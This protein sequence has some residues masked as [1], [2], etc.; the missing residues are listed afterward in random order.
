MTEIAQK[1][2]PLTQENSRI[3]KPTSQTLLDAQLGFLDNNSNSTATLNFRP[4][5][6]EAGIESTK[7]NYESEV[8]HSQDHE[9]D[10]KEKIIRDDSIP[11]E[12]VI[13]IK[14]ALNF[15]ETAQVDSRAWNINMACVLCWKAANQILRQEAAYLFNM[16]HPSKQDNDGIRSRFLRFAVVLMF[17]IIPLLIV[18]AEVVILIAILDEGCKIG[19]LISGDGTFQLPAF[20][21]VKYPQSKKCQASALLRD[22][23]QEPNDPSTCLFYATHLANFSMTAPPFGSPAF[24]S[25]YAAASKGADFGANLDWVMGHCF[26][27]AYADICL[28]VLASNASADAVGQAGCNTT[29]GAGPCSFRNCYMPQLITSQFGGPPRVSAQQWKGLRVPL[30]EV[31]ALIL[32]A[33]AAREAPQPLDQGRLQA[34]Y[35]AAFAG[36][37]AQAAYS[38]ATTFACWYV[39]QMVNSRK[40]YASTSDDLSLYLYQQVQWV[41]VLGFGDCYLMEYIAIVFLSLY[42]YMT[43]IY[44]ELT[45][46]LYQVHA[47]AAYS[48]PA[49]ICEELLGPGGGALRVAPRY[50]GLVLKSVI[51]DVFMALRVIYL[52]CVV[53]ATAMII[54]W[55]HGVME[56]AVL[57]FAVSSP[58]SLARSLAPSLFSLPPLLRS[59]AWSISSLYFCAPCV[60]PF[61]P[62]AFL[63]SSPPAFLSPRVA[64]LHPF[65]PHYHH[66]RF[67]S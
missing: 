49:D 36:S 16:E 55:N 64:Y 11:E 56:V 17:R 24:L 31:E 14:S 40:T 22:W 46:A 65:F 59:L 15:E 25:S 12:G 29:R 42:V 27:W 1:P 67:P 66:T 35:L 23:L 28:H 10:C 47:F 2:A 5:L 3:I 30:D 34:E 63:P 50:A 20:N 52:A 43:A 57:A 51:C 13:R 41:Y 8:R 58:S 45:Q 54:S 38:N 33:R 19:F 61:P 7:Q 6:L 21:W 32:A 48:S 62:L 53:Q 26:P 4:Q 9:N 37:R 60:L 18:L 39:Q 44:D